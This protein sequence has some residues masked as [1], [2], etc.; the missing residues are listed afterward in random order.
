MRRALPGLKHNSIEFKTPVFVVPI[1]FDEACACSINIALNL[2]AL[3]LV[4]QYYRA[5]LR[6][7]FL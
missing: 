3:G 1:C 4:Q 6:G 7:A 5:S 2:Q